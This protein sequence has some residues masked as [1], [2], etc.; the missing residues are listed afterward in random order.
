MVSALGVSADL[1][2]PLTLVLLIVGVPMLLIGLRYII[3]YLN[4]PE[5]ADNRA[6]LALQMTSATVVTVVGG[7]AAAIGIGLVQFGDIAAM[8]TMFI[9]NHPFIVSNLAGIGLGAGALS[10]LLE[11]SADQYIGIALMIVAGVFIA[12]EVTDRAA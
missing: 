12:S 3:A 1:G 5:S 10:G 8:V 2:D 4:T 7:I 9:G 11:L 6:Q